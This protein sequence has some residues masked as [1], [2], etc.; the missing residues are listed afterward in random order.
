[1]K[2]IQLMK[3]TF[4]LEKEIKGK[5]ANF[6]M[7]SKRLSMGS[8]CG[9]FE[10]SFAK[11]QG[12]KF[13]TMV[14]S[15][16]SANLAL[17]QSLLNLK[18]LKK[19]EKVGLSAVTWATN[20][21][22]VIQLGLAPILIDVELDTLNISSNTV[23]AIIKRHPDMKALFV[24][25][26]L[27]FCGD[28]D[29]IS[30][31][32]RLRKIIL[33]EDNCESLGSV[34]KN[35]KLGNYGL[36]STNSFFVGHH[37]SAIEG[38]AVCTDNEDLSNMLKMVRAHGWDRSLSAALKAR[39]RRGNR[40]SKFYDQYT[41]Y[42]LGYNLRPTEVTGFLAQQ[43]LEHLDQIISLR[44][45]NYFKFYEATL[46]NKDFHQLNL[47][48]FQCISNFAFPVIC[49]SKATMERY[50][51]LFEKNLIEIR[52]IVGGNMARQPFFKDCL[53]PQGELKNSDL[54]HNNGFYFPNNPELNNSEV[55]RI[56]NL[57]NS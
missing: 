14:N 52:P 40:V 31:F 56:C 50:V 19:G 2:P 51:K 36:A 7:R 48:G 4:F 45:S 22:P 26:L 34:Y 9:N 29:V 49:K 3:S 33:L 42:E 32:C 12:A 25:N 21:M 44:Q 54:I 55:K 27:G 30:E 18:M 6:I 37:L 28:L 23:E 57:L 10:E 20:V 15:G 39:Y 53:K 1:M 41:F 16:S 46:G 17:L 35:I 38:G 13:S 43:Q 47:S 11:W 8:C 5:L 24:T